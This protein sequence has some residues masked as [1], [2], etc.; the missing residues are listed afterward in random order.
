[1]HPFTP[2]RLVHNLIEKT[3]EESPQ[4]RFHRFEPATLRLWVWHRTNWA[5]PAL[6]EFCLFCIPSVL[7]LTTNNCVHVFHKQFQIARLGFRFQ[8]KNLLKTDRAQ[9]VMGVWAASSCFRDS[10]IVI[11][12][13]AFET[14]KQPSGQ[15]TGLLIV[16]VWDTRDRNSGTA[17]D[18][19][20]VKILMIFQVQTCQCV[21]PF[22]VY[23]QAQNQISTSK[24]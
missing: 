8:S 24:I 20:R 23:R 18:T 17:L 9:K 16:V 1:M 22:S 13:L 15:H 12:L 6:E 5:F 3:C 19:F 2:G 7:S 10:M 11:L 14:A 4:E 21:N